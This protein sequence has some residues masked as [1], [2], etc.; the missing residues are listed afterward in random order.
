M[1]LNKLKIAIDLD[2]TL[3]NSMEIFTKLHHDLFPNTEPPAWID[4][5]DYDLGVTFNANPEIQLIIFEQARHNSHYK[6]A[7]PC[8]VNFHTW[9]KMLQADGHELFIITKNP[10]H[11]EPL[12]KYWL[13]KYGLSMPIHF[14]NSMARKFDYEWDVLIDDCPAIHKQF[15]EEGA[16]EG[17]RHLMVYMQPWNKHCYHDPSRN[18]YHVYNWRDVFDNCNYLSQH[19]EELN[20]ED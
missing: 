14:V 9:V 17:K 2:N 12:I 11:M 8:D 7:A 6:Y 16:W 1:K 15:I 20:G 19:K 4:L 13:A 5:N 10:E 3:V 18:I